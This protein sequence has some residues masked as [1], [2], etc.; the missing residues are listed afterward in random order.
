MREIEGFI[1]VGGSS[2]R[3]GTDK[4][5]LELGG[6]NFVERIFAALAPISTQT[7][8][9]GDRVGI[10][11]LPTFQMVPDVHVKWGALGGLHAALRSCRAQWAAVVACDLPFVTG[12]LFV[13]LASLRENFDAVVPVQTDGRLQ[14]LCS[15]YRAEVCLDQADQL[16]AAGERRPRALFDRVRARKVAFTELADLPGAT[17]FFV[18]VNTPE[19][20]NDALGK[21]KNGR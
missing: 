9:V 7:S 20:Y 6:R 10:V 12:D 19:E 18:N 17:R 21:E 13:R 8:L 3:M 1:L 4:A 16:I 2:S 11:G 14:P 15:L 5:L